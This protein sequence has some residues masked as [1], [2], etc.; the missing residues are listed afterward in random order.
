MD[1][2]TNINNT[3]ISNIKYDF[4]DI[5]SHLS[6]LSKIEKD[7]PIYSKQHVDDVVIDTSTT[8][9]ITLSVNNNNNIA[10]CSSLSHVRTHEH[11]NNLPSEDH[12][13]I[14]MQNVILLNL[15]NVSSISNLNNDIDQPSSIDYVQ[16][17]TLTIPMDTLSSNDSFIKKANNKK[18]ERVR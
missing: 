2:T 1:N 12:V 6:T 9:Q 4:N 15:I 11:I 5:P 13:P 10:T 3:S 8:A 16:S 18:K 7:P 17:S 14:P